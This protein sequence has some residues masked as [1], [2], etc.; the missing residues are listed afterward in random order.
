VPTLAY[1]TAIAGATH[2]SAKVLRGTGRFAAVL[3]LTA[4]HSAPIFLL[5]LLSPLLL[6]PSISRWIVIILII[7]LIILDLPTVQAAHG[8]EMPKGIIAGI[9]IPMLVI[10]VL[11][12]GVYFAGYR[13]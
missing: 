10:A 1:F 7:Y 8:F 5:T 6:P 2:L 11:A 4:A 12:A 3:Y 9:V 13:V